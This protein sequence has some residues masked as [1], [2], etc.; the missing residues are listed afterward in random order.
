MSKEVIIKLVKE[1][2]CLA[3]QML[4]DLRR[5]LE[6]GNDL[7]I[8]YHK[9]HGLGCL[10]KFGNDQM[11]DFNLDLCTSSEGEL[12]GFEPYFFAR[13]LLQSEKKDLFKDEKEIIDFL[14]TMKKNGEIF[15]EELENNISYLYYLKEDYEYLM[16]EKPWEKKHV[17]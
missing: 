8:T 16:R 7:N 6:N 4:L 17:E 13:Y 11:L 2:L 14:N 1:Y 10:V 9:Y 15:S 3:N 12:V 5:G